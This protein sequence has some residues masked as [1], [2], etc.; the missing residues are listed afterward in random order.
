MRVRCRQRAERW[1][2]SPMPRRPLL[3]GRRHIGAASPCRRAAPAATGAQSCQW[4]A[5]Q[6]VERALAGPALSVSIRPS[7]RLNSCV[8]ISTSN[9]R[10]QSGPWG[11][12]AG[13]PGSDPKL[14]LSRREQ[15]L[16]QQIDDWIAQI[17]GVFTCRH[18]D[19]SLRCWI[20]APSELSMLGTSASGISVEPSLMVSAWGRREERVPG[21]AA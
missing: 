12:C 13:G 2:W 8:W 16:S 18:P 21:T 10:H 19:N 4:R 3:P 17:C 1:Q 6:R 20:C 7:S 15:S 5:R 11:E 9:A 14:V